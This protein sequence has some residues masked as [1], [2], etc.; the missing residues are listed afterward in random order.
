MSKIDS[1][2]IA[3][4]KQIMKDNPS[5][6]E[7]FIVEGSGHL[8]SKIENA[9]AQAAGKSAVYKLVA[10][11]DQP[12]LVKEDESKAGKEKS[13]TPDKTWTVDALKSFALENNIDLG[14]ASK[15]DEVLSKVEAALKPTE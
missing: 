6:K 8:Y 13:L 7:I 11:S 12:E 5:E 2:Q 3:F 1:K 4:A 15:K 9:R 10:G 14:T